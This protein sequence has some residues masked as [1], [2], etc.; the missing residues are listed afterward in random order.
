MDKK[1]NYSLK[2]SRSIFNYTITDQNI[3][4][5]IYSWL[6]YLDLEKGFSEKTISS[7]EIDF[8]KFLNFLCWYKKNKY[9]DL[10]SLSKDNLI[11]IISESNELTLQ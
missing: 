4:N 2:N 7:Y 11:K 8:R 1:L 10:S 3:K 6:K 9:I 5:Y